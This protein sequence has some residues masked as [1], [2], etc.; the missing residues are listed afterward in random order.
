MKSG[1]RL[2]VSLQ[3]A[4]CFSCQTARHENAA[5]ESGES[6][7]ATVMPV[8]GDR[9]ADFR[10]D[11]V[12]L[13]DSG[14]HFGTRWVHSENG[15]PVTT[16]Q[17]QSVPQVMLH[18]NTPPVSN[19]GEPHTGEH[20]LLG[21]GRK[22]K[23]L[24]AEKGMSLVRSTAYTQQTDVVYSWNCAAGK[25]TFFRSVETY[26]NALLLPDYSDEEIRREVCHLG[27][28]RD[29]KSGEFRIE[30]KGTV[31]QEM[32]TNYER[33]WIAWYQMLPRV[34]GENHPLSYSSGGEP[35]AIRE[36]TPADIREFHSAC[37]HLSANMGIIASL[38]SSISDEEFLQRLAKVV[39][40]LE[41]TPALK[42]RPK[43][44]QSIPPSQGQTDRSLQIVSYPSANENDIGVAL[45]T[46]PAV[47]TTTLRDRLLAEL[48]MRTLGDGER[49]VFYKR[50]MD[51]TTR[52][53]EIDASSVF[54]QLLETKINI[55]AMTGFDGLSPRH[56][57]AEQVS[58]A[59]SVIAR[60]IETLAQQPVGSKELLDFNQKAIAQLIERQKDLRKRLNSP[61]LFGHRSVRGFWLEHL[62][63][64]DL[65][66]GTTRPVALRPTFESIREEL[67]AGE[68]PWRALITHLKLNETPYIT[69]SVPSQ[70]ERVRVAEE[71]DDRYAAYRRS[72]MQT[73]QTEDEQR[74]IALYA[75]D[76]ESKSRTLRE[77]ETEL[78]K[79]QLVEDVPLHPD[80]TLEWEE[81]TI[82]GV[83]GFR[84]LF[85]NMSAA[86]ISLY[87]DLHGVVPSHYVWLALLPSLLTAA[88]IDDGDAKIPY[89][90]MQERLASEIYSL[91]A[92]YSMRPARDRHELRITVSGLDRV[93]SRLAIQWLVRCLHA[94]WISEDNLPRLRDLVRQRIREIRTTLG[95]REEQWVRNPA[96]TIRYQD[97]ALY[98]STTSHHAGLFYLAR[99]EWLLTEPP[100]SSER[101][102]VFAAFDELASL[103]GTNGPST[104]D[105]LN[106]YARR[107]KA[108]SG[109]ARAWTLPFVERLKELV[110]DMAPGSLAGDLRAVVVQAKADISV[111]PRVALREANDLRTSLLRRANC[112]FALTGSAEHT[113]EL[114]IQLTPI[115]ERLTGGAKLDSR[116]PRAAL[117]STRIRDH[118]TVELSPIH[119]GFVQAGATT[120]VFVLSTPMP[121]LDDVGDE[122][123]IHG[124]A[125]SVFGGAGPHGFFMKTWGAGLAYSNGIGGSATGGRLSYYAERCPDLVETMKFV[126]GLV[127]AVD[128]LDDPYLAEYA[129]ARRV[130]QSRAGDSYEQRTH[131]MAD[132]LVD[133]DTPECISRY[134]QAVL[135]LRK[136]V[137]VWPR[138]KQRIQTSTGRVLPGVGPV[139]RESSGTFVVIAPE[140]MLA[141]WESWVQDHE[142]AEERV[143]RVY[144]RDLWVTGA[145]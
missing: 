2:L 107:M 26:L 141:R 52:E 5:T 90:V 145:R 144:G 15:M 133:G 105:A 72:L 103:A 7:M 137:D 120:G 43:T 102:E 134:R 16:L 78:A 100:P 143:Y 27:V 40:E 18:F 4:L 6:T 95:G 34:F 135:D 97:D 79:P 20:L 29:E 65:Q 104:L 25:E 71:K 127:A 119:Y 44:V 21:K 112:R 96:D 113:G 28:V 80:P 99:L 81:H 24:A 41:A 62:R 125:A 38:P 139:S 69:V 111:E 106:A 13:D 53:V 110:G 101:D 8:V 3:L 83:R 76:Y 142:G 35:G 122:D 14:G 58:A 66:K 64:L 70:D 108:A 63:L 75:D 42:S 1:T 109:V 73:Y 56:A 98:V 91:N 23:K 51:R 84:G 82:A 121:G 67:E 10:V 37:Y 93:E 138:L 32:L 77:I 130:T 57:N 59:A 94:P 12:Y 86:E 88:G 140:P 17:I 136:K 68:N 54:G 118:Q 55:A 92:T 74:A 60:E 85:S 115:L 22:G 117:V 33:R 123:V 9:L 11:T 19:G 39:R 46:W 48:L 61:P 47:E 128:S 50:F 49:S 30:E 132:A 89:D 116:L 87:F 126:T 124:L 131:A 31:Y 45:L 129:V 114:L 36:T